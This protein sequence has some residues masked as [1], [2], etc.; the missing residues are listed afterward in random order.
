MKDNKKQK[1]KEKYAIQRNKNLEELYNRGKVNYIIR[2]GVLSWGVSTG[3]IFILL[4]GLFQHGFSFKEVLWG[5]LSSNA[6]FVLG[7]FAVG[8][9]IWGS[10]MWKWLTKEIEKNKTRKK[11]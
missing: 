8:G 7:I 4:T 5:V 11:Q 9:F 2:H 10:I 1:T 6:L 3:I